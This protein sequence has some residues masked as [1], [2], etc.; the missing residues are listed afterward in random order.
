[1]IVACPSMS[2]AGKTTTQDIMPD[3]VFFVPVSQVGQY[4]EHWEEV[5]GVPDTVKGITPTRNWILDN[6]DDP[7]VVQCDDDGIGFGYMQK[8]A[9]E[10]GTIRHDKGKSHPKMGQD[11][12]RRLLLSCFDMCEDLGTN[13]FGFGVA[14]DLSSTGSLRRCRWCPWWWGT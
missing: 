6:T 3:V 5:V 4:K 9:G 12:I 10:D 1:M 11:D 7:H 2:R 8:V 14:D 13:L